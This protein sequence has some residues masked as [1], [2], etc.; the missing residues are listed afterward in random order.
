MMHMVLFHSFKNCFAGLVRIP[1]LASKVGQECL[2]KW[3]GSVRSHLRAAWTGQ[4]SLG[5]GI[6]GQNSFMSRWDSSEFL[7]EL[8]GLV[9][10]LQKASGSVENSFEIMQDWPEF[11]WKGAG[12]IKIPLIFCKTG[13]NSFGRGQNWL[14]F[15]WKGA[16][17][18]R[19]PLKS[20]RIGQSSF[21]RGQAW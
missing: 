18:V 21:G 11:L 3:A 17:L 16:G 19:I 10:N 13:Q 9:R 14:E 2:W 15:L 8:A 5:T 1:S 6:I 12:I 7:W 20:G 4:I